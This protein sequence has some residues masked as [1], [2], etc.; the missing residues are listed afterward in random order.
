M[1]LSI[2]YRGPLSS[3][4][5]ECHYC[6]FAKRHE[7]AAELKRDEQALRRF[8]AWCGQQ[9]DRELAVFITPWGEA[10]VRRW[11]QHAL[12]QLSHLPHIRRVA[13]QTNLSCRLDW[14]DQCD[15]QRVALWCTWHPTEVA[16]DDFLA[17]CFALE[18]RQIRY[19]IGV[20]GLREAFAAI[21]DL[22]RRMPPHVYLWINAFKDEG[23]SYYEPSEIAFL[24]S[25]DPYFRANL[26]DHASFGQR[27]HTGQSVITVDGDGNIR[28]CHFIPAVIG[29][30]YERDWSACL[31]PRLCTN[32]TC[33]CHIGYIHMPHLEQQ[34][35]YGEG[36]L[37]RIPNWPGLYHS[38]PSPSFATNAAGGG[39]ELAEP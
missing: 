5:Y 32:G 19:S 20:V 38:N 36:L 10:L 4:N 33:S 30:I 13:I 1:A 25:V 8:V 14:L 6:P 11:Y 29:N 21:A 26:I 7:T 17:Q 35:I 34:A 2:L 22:R 31:Q 12:A 23:S 3:C 24:E 9:T 39:N 37:E 27:C 15:R 28:R 16:L 18:E